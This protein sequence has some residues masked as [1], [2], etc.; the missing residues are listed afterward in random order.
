[1]LVDVNWTN[2]YQLIKSL[3]TFSFRSA[4]DGAKPGDR[5]RSTPRNPPVQRS[6]RQCQDGASP[7]RG[8]WCSSRVSRLKGEDI[9]QGRMF[10][11][12]ISEITS[13]KTPLNT[14]WLNVHWTF[15]DKILRILNRN[16]NISFIEVIWKYRL[17][18][19][20]IVCRPQWLNSNF[21]KKCTVKPLI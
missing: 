4:E 20:P 13:G 15:R 19:V 8:T 10:T 3:P 12:H 1:M 9:S 7:P 14:C 21:V 6:G 18:N 17:P 16:T 2:D 5:S 11:Q